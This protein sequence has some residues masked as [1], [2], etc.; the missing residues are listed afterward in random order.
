V[1]TLA[2]WLAFAALVYIV[3]VKARWWAGPI[4]TYRRRRQDTGQDRTPD[5]TRDR[6]GQRLRWSWRGTGQDTPPE[7]DTERGPVLPSERGAG[8]ARTVDWA[9]GVSV[10]Y[11]DD[12]QR[13]VRVVRLP[14][15]PTPLE[16]LLA[17]ATQNADHGRGTDAGHG[18][19]GKAT[20]AEIRAYVR[21][22]LAERP[23]PAATQIDRDGAELFGCSTKSIQRARLMIERK[24]Q[25]RRGT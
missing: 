4:T 9:P 16:E 18:V 21:Q 14:A 8:D 11:D 6:T 25:H 3:G 1:D 19:Q 15:G 22:R 10:S 13:R 5:L 12:A 7:E 24:Q 20:P 17:T 2:N 23:R